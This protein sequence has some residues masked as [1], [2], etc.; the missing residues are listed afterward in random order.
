MRRGSTTATDL[1][2]LGVVLW[3]LLTG[4]E[5]YQESMN[6]AARR[7]GA[8]LAFVQL[9]QPPPRPSERIQANPAGTR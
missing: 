3:K 6:R 7:R 1:Y 9:T 4:L 5:P 8:A 2:A